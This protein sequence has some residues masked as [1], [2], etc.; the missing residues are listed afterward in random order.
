MHGRLR[1]R[2]IRG[3]DE[4]VQIGESPQ[5]DVSVHGFREH[6]P[7]I[8]N[9]GNAMGFKA[10]QNPNKFMREPETLLHVTFVV[11][12]QL[13]Q[14]RVRHRVWERGKTPIDYRNYGMMFG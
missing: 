10:V 12:P 6:R 14:H 7:L 3:M 4:D 8:W 13:L 5:S 9:C 11:L 1:A 2:H